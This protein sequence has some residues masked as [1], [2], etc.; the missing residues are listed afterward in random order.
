MSWARRFGP[1][2]GVGLISAA[3][4]AVGVGVTT[5]RSHD[6][7]REVRS[8]NEERVDARLDSIEEWKSDHQ[9]LSDRV[10]K[11]LSARLS[12]LEITQA[13]VLQ[14]VNRL[15]VIKGEPPMVIPQRQ[16]TGKPWMVE[17][18]EAADPGR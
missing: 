8:K 1:M 16:E 11:E 15:L 7:D 14:G 9:E 10:I 18:A 12:R 13:V 3:V 17:P 5:C 2:I 6:S 4:T